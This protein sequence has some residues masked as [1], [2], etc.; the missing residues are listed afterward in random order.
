MSF[1][2][3][4]RRSVRMFAHNK[5]HFAVYERGTDE[6]NAAGVRTSE[7]MS[8]PDEDGRSMVVFLNLHLLMMLRCTD[9]KLRPSWSLSEHSHFR[10]LLT[11]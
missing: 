9:E 3:L 5:A 6:P 8:R 7:M 10:F 1:A 2:R 11:T 4:T